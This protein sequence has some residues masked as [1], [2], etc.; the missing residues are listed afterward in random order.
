MSPKES[1][2]LLIEARWVLPMLP[3]NTALTDHAVV[4]TGGRI[5]A[6][7][8]AEQMRERFAAR[9]SVVRAEHALMPGF[10][11]AHTRAAAA[12]FRGIPRA[13]AASAAQRFAGPEL[14]KEAAQMAIAEMLRAGITCFAAADLFPEETARTAAAAHLRAAIGLPVSDEPNPWAESSVAH[15]AKAEQ[16]WDIYRSDPLV[17]LYFA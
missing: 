5:A 11:N 2:D 3:V 13:A 6:I 8:P 15:L 4:V 10:V 12:L 17:S 1:A 9:E 7:G 14:I 16:L